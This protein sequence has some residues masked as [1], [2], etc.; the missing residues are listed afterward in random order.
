[1]ANDKFRQGKL[2]LDTSVEPFSRHGDRATLNCIDIMGEIGVIASY[3]MNEL[4]QIKN[5]SESEF[6]Y[7]ECYCPILEDPDDDCARNARDKLVEENE[8]AQALLA[9]ICQKVND[10]ADK[11][12]AKSAQEQRVQELKQSSVFNEF[13][14][15]WMRKSKFWEKLRGEI[16]G[17][18]GVGGGFGGTGGGDDLGA[19]GKHKGGDTGTTGL[20]GDK[21][22]GAGGEKKQGPKFPAV[23]L[24]N[25]DE[26]PLRFTDKVNCEPGHP[27]VYQRDVDVPE[28][29]FWINTQ[30]PFA[31]KIRESRNYGPD[32]TRWREY[33]FQRHM[34]ILIKQAVYETEKRESDLS[35]ARID[36][37]L[38]KIYKQVYESAAQDPSLE[39]FLFKESL[40]AYAV[41]RDDA[42]KAETET[43]AQAPHH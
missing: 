33:L 39:S 35:A 25:Y 34:D 19:K 12:A 37:L 5:F 41:E 3:R 17:G 38:D 4:G 21:G 7:G 15:S 31:K 40:S 11:M 43:A 42:V 2:T 29:I 27:P 26:D 36:G 22:G 10:L 9:W 16:F 18:P 28:S 20:D 1:M 32:S 14:N 6:I 23:L 24:S 8:K 13:L 30:S